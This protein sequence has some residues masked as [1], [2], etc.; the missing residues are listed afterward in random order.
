M[1][2]VTAPQTRLTNRTTFWG[3]KLSGKPEA[4]FPWNS[5]AK[6]RTMLSWSNVLFGVHQVKWNLNQKEKGGKD[7][8]EF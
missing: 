4:T 7:P 1:K 5:K 3:L 2:G 8:E 6:L